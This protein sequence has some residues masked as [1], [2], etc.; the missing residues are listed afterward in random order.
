MMNSDTAACIPAA[1]LGRS[2]LTKASWRLVPLLALGYATAY[3]DRV[4]I[5]FASLQMNRDLG[6]SASV[7]GLGAGLFFISY[8]FC[9]IPSNL[10]LV[11]FGARRWLSRIMFTWG[12]LAIGM[13]F[14]RSPREFYTMR[15]LLGLAEAGFF[16]GV[17]FYLTEWFPPEHRARTISRFYIALPLSSTL[18][19]AIAEVLLSLDGRF[20]AAGWQWLFALEGFPALILSVIFF[21]YLPDTPADATWLT[22][23]ERIWLQTE[24]STAR[25]QATKPSS[26]TLKD[27]HTVLTDRRTWLIGLFFLFALTTL[28]GYAFSAPSILQSVTGLSVGWTGV[29]IAIMGIFGAA[30]MLWNARHSDRSNERPLHIIV[31]FLLMAAGYFIAG[32]TRNPVCFVFAITLTVVAYNAAQGPALALPATFLT[33]RTAA[34]GYAVVNAVGMTGGFFG[35]YWMGRARDLTGNYQHG[36]LT[37]AI[38]SV[39]AS[40]CIFLLRFYLPLKHDRQAQSFE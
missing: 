26:H 20:S 13:V 10:L 24:L 28:Y 12:M 29:L 21:L 31:P 33:G 40:S 4:N 3:M 9:E 34:I 19:G 37:L 15:F 25:A 6:F 5:S 22:P 1:D 7:Y 16:P 35:P 8:A 39:A 18:M 27:L 17:V 2:A 38:P 23:E 11:R 36:L 32:L 14:V 30:A